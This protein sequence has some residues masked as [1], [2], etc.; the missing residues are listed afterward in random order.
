MY[1]IGLKYKYQASRTSDVA[2]MS[3]E[4]TPDTRFNF[5]SEVNKDYYFT[6]L[7]SIWLG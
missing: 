3:G 4:M 6:S 2:I 1:L 5:K 7:G